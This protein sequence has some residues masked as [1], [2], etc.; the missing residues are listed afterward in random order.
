MYLCPRTSVVVF[1]DGRYCLHVDGNGTGTQVDQRTL[2]QLMRLRLI[3]RVP[4]VDPARYTINDRGRAALK[5]R[6]QVTGNYRCPNCPH[7]NGCGFD[8]Q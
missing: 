3:S 6:A 7:P 4:D 2:E 8:G 1:K 5:S